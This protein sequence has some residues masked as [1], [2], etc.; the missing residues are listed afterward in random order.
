[1]KS[2]SFD[3][4]KSIQLKG[5]AILFMFWIHLYCHDEKLKDGVYYLSVFMG[6]NIYPIK[7]VLKLCSICVPL[8][9][10]MAGYA[11]GVNIGKKSASIRAIIN[12]LYFKYWFVFLV[13]IPIC[14][15]VGEINFRFFECLKNLSGFYYTYCGEWWFFSLYIEL[16]IIAYLIN[17]LTGWKQETKLIIGISFFLM[18]AGYGL[19]V[20][21]PSVTTGNTLINL[22]YT[23][24]IKQPIF[25]SG[26]ICAREN[27][28]KKLFPKAGKLW[29]LYLT[30]WVFEFTNIPESLY[31]PLIIPGIVFAFCCL[32]IEGKTGRI[33]SFLGRQSTYMWLTHS[34]LIYKLMQ[35]I[36]YGLHFSILNY[37]ILLL[38]DIPIAVTLN[39]VE[40]WI[41]NRCSNNKNLISNT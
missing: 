35:Q 1:M 6:D 17:K 3:K 5:I 31:L 29:P 32:K 13:F 7:F 20:V 15:M 2:I 22:L 25:I 19:K 10:F 27:Y 21:I 28:F 4:N 30:G 23:F 16:E 8:F 11:Y 40:K 12:K 37:I 33:L 36:I 38:V 14:I 39:W 41:K 34:L 18:C 26:L 24:L 9:I